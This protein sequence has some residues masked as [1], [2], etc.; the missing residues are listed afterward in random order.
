MVRPDRLGASFQR[1]RLP[2]PPELSEE[3]CLVLETSGQVEMIGT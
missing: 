1:L 3:R 2:I